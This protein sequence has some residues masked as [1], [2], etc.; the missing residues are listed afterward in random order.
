[1]KRKAILKRTLIVVLCQLLGYHALAQELHFSVRRDIDSLGMAQQFAGASECGFSKRVELSFA[2]D[3]LERVRIGDYDHMTFHDALT[4]GNAGE[5]VTLTVSRTLTLEKGAIVCGVELVGGE[6]VEIEDAIYPA[7]QRK[8]TSWVPSARNSAERLQNESIYSSDALFPG[9]TIDCISGSNG[10]NTEVYL[11]FYPIQFNP[12]MRKAYLVVNA[13]IEVYYSIVPEPIPEAVPALVT[14]ARNIIITSEALLEG[15]NAIKALHE[16]RENT[17]TEIITTEW[18][19]TNYPEAPPTTIKGY[20]TQTITYVKAE[21]KY[22]LARRLVSY[23]RDT[24]AH[25]NLDSITILGDAA[26]VPPSYYFYCRGYDTGYSNWIC[27][28]LFYSSPDYDYVLN[29]KTGRLPAA[30]ADEAVLM[31][32]KLTE[33]KN[34]LSRSWFHNVTLV[35][36]NPFENETLIGE[37]LTLGP[38][39]RGYLR[40]MNITKNFWSTQTENKN[41]V[42]TA[43]SDGNTGFVFHMGHG[44][45]TTMRFT[46][47]GINYDDLMSLDPQIKYPIV[48]SIACM[49]G[50]YDAELMRKCDFKNSFAEG[51]LRSKAGGIAYW[52]GVRMTTGVPD[53]TFGSGG[54]VIVADARYM[55]TM[56]NYIFVAYYSGK[57]TFGEINNAA[58]SAYAASLNQNDTADKATFYGFVFLGDPVLSLLPQNTHATEKL[59]RVLVSLLPNG[60]WTDAGEPAYECTPPDFPELKYSIATNSNSVK[61]RLCQMTEWGSSWVSST[62]AELGLKPF[63]YLYTSDR[64]NLAYCLSFETADFKESRVLFFLKKK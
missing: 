15:A 14:Q 53:V 1:M 49:N 2:T 45:G 34:N 58:I 27:S 23:L 57:K 59:P 48:I 9:K 24:P 56:L 44:S 18:V 35:G 28:D 63:K 10:K 50:G 17:P 13:E 43:F 54:Q 61:V 19:D 25:P 26:I 62:S 47:E 6:Y 32:A 52:G 21:Y 36:G 37:L 8:P 11:Q 31:A 16:T 7:P 5:P 39:N 4:T 3:D 55:P 38:L 12:L 20:A 22:S 33:W 64:C 30:N 51:V 60:G 29:F 40:G 42:M 46:N 41:T